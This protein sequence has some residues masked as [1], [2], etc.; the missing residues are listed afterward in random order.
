MIRIFP[1]RTSYTPDDPLVFIG[2]PPL[3][4][5]PDMPVR[6]SCTF[7]WDMEQCEALAASWAQYYSDVQ[8]GGPAYGS[9]CDT[10]TPGQF[11]KKGIIFT[12]RGC[13][14]QCGYCFVPGKEGEIKELPIHD[15]WVVQD[16]NLLQCSESH[17]RAVF[18]MLRRQRNPAEFKGGFE[19]RLFHE[20]HLDLLNSIRWSSVFFAADT[21][22]ALYD[23]ERVSSLMQGI[24]I[25]KKRC[26]VL[27]GY[28]GET[29]DDAK[30]RLISVYRLGFLPFVQY[31]QGEIRTEKDRAWQDF[32][33]TWSLPAAY[34][35][36]M[37]KEKHG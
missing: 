24:S 14:N 26:Y 37:K 8:V 19:A 1:Y 6:V 27:A 23:L 36:E 16:N 7:T 18:D 17:I 13:N 20:W 2:E 33:R 4:R 28:D 12:S 34:K 3:F 9:P 29:I 31:Y 5:P 32:I 30:T 10:F 21:N 35:S 15:G 22:A 11:V 25:N